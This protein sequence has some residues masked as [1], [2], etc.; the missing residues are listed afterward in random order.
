MRKQGEAGIS[1]TQGTLAAVKRVPCMQ[2]MVL[3]RAM[4]PLAT[5]S[6]P[7]GREL[8]QKYL[9]FQSPYAFGSPVSAC[10]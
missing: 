3:N 5:Q 1:K 8:S 2:N 4:Q 10:H 7:D 6:R 9:G